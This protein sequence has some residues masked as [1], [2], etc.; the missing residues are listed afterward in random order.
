[1][2]DHAQFSLFGKRAVVTG[3]SRGLGRGMAVA[4]ATAGADVVCIGRS[5]KRLEVTIQDIQDIGRKA[6]PLAIDLSNRTTRRTIADLAEDRAGPIDI[7][8]NNAGISRRHSAHKFPIKDWDIVLETNLNAVFEL[9]L[10]FGRRMIKR[11][12]GKIVNIASLL[13]FSGGITIPAYTAA[14]HGVAG[15]TKALANEWAP[16]NIQVNAIAPGYF[17]TELTQPLYDDPIRRPEL[18]ARIPA[19]KWGRPSDL[20]GP[21]VFLASDASDYVNGHILVVDG[22]WMAR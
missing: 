1:M 20:G 13:S 21:V 22:G 2:N 7:L 5:E 4:L 15:L 9:C 16:F 14:K 19:G 11:K 12:S 3:A 17:L 6:W 8:V 10:Q 18:D